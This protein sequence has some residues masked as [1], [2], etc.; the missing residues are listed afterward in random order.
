MPDVAVRVEKLGK[1]FR[2]GAPR[3]RY[4]TFRD[5]VAGLFKRSRAERKS[6]REPFWALRDVSLEIQ[7][8][9]VVGIIGRNGAGKSTLLK[10]LA[11]ITEPTEG[12]AEI[13]GRVGSLLEVGTGFHP[14]LTG[15]ENV[16]LNGAILGMRRAEIEAKF[17]EIIAFA[18]IEKF[19]DTPV[20]HYSSGMY[21]RLAFSVAAHLEPEILFVDEV[22]AVGD[23]VFQRKCLARMREVAEHGLTI[24]FVSHNMAAIQ[25]L[26]T[27]ALLLAKGRL[28]LAGPVESVVQG[29]LKAT[30]GKQDLNLESI[31]DRKGA[32]EV[33]IREIR[34]TAPDG[35]PL[36]GLVC[37]KPARIRLGLS[38]CQRADKPRV[39]LCLLDMMDQR[40]MLLDSQLLGKSLP[41]V[42]PGGSLICDIPRVSLAPGR[43]KIELWLQVNEVLQDWISD[44]GT[45]EVLDGDFYRSG[46]ALPSGGQFA[47][48]D[49]AWRP[50]LDGG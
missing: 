11:R 3:E 18:E 40:I 23:A 50:A 6:A 2:I 45:V 32:G 35:S 1:R 22:L 15:R 7:R 34:I 5:A 31:T 21:L 17:D 9:E 44:A 13:R 24:L 46:M 47:V 41:P 20:K 12:F 36:A 30:A 28:A 16:F 33:R 37:G 25:H 4:K 8:G 43:Y 10:V 27:R 39:S 42:D 14:E 29:Y 38:N 48:M 19:I 49:F 26:C